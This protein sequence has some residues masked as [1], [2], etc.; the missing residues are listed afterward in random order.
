MRQ[1]YGVRLS[2]ACELHTYGTHMPMIGA[3]YTFGSQDISSALKLSPL[4]LEKGNN[5]ACRIMCIDSIFNTVLKFITSKQLLSSCF[6]I[7]GFGLQGVAE[8]TIEYCSTLR[9]II[10][11]TFR[12]GGGRSQP[13]RIVG[14]NYYSNVVILYDQRVS[15][16]SN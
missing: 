14:F 3:P 8:Q 15:P 1:I 6:C 13:N 12:K 16:L 11:L 4:T 5:H 2:Q 7:F 9:P 10:V